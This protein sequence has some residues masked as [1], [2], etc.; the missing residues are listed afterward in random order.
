[1]CVCV[2]EAD[3]VLWEPMGQLGGSARE[4]SPVACGRVIVGVCDR[5]G[6]ICVL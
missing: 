1:M 6:R 5:V 2:C 4:A 3:R